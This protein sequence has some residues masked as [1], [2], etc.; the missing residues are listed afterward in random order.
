MTGVS[1]AAGILFFFIVSNKKN[2]NFL[3]LWPKFHLW[4]TPGV[5]SCFEC[6]NCICS[7]IGRWQEVA[8]AMI[9]G[10]PLKAA[11]IFWASAKVENCWMDFMVWSRGWGGVRVIPSPPSL[12][13]I[14]ELSFFFLM[15]SLN[16]SWMMHWRRHQFGPEPGLIDICSQ[17]DVGPAWTVVESN[18]LIN[19]RLI[20]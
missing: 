11:E 2:N 16:S 5:T 6:E 15:F 13:C 3:L 4:L 18:Y 10:F 8:A 12:Y 20:C 17:T 1:G 19:N 9:V 7:V 14:T